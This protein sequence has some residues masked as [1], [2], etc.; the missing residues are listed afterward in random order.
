LTWKAR[1]FGVHTRFIEL[2]GEINSAMPDYVMSKLSAALNQR[3]KSVN[4]STILVLGLAYKKNVDDTRESPAV[5]L[6]EKL[7]MLGATVL[8]SDPHVPVFPKMREHHFELASSTITAELLSTCDCVVV[9][10]DH[11][12]FDFDH[13]VQHSTLI[14]D[15]RG[16]YRGFYPNVVKA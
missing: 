11:D 16:R 1:E 6:M 7:R 2:A 9:A 15:T 10:T 5:V 8:Y 13:L 3:R 12:Q 4:G 14:I